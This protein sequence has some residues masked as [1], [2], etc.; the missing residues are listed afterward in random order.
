MYYWHVCCITILMI[1]FDLD[2]KG[3]MKL[4]Q[5]RVA[6]MCPIIRINTN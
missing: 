6:N 4:R 1:D 5:K 3:G 2:L